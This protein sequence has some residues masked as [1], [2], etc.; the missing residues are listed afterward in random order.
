V[1]DEPVVTEEA[2]VTEAAGEVTPARMDLTVAIEKSGPCKKH[3]RVTVPREAIDEVL[4]DAVQELVDSADVP[5][6]RK[7]HVPDQLIRRR[8]KKELS[9]QVKQKVLMRSLEQ[10]SEDEELEPINEPNLDLDSIDVPDE[11]DFEYEFDIEVRPEFELPNY[12]GLK[13]ERPVRE[14]TEQNID[15][16]IQELLEQY[17][18]LEPVDE[19]AAAGD[20]VTLAIEFTH[21]GEPL[22]QIDEI[23]VR[24]RPTL[25][26][27][28]GELA[29]FD[30][31]MI[32][33]GADD[34]READ[35]KVSMEADTI[36][37]RGETVHARCTV[38]DVKRLRAQELNQEFLD[39]LSIDSVE[40]LR[41]QVR[42]M[43]E[44]QVTYE[45]RQATRQQVLAKITDSADWD[46]PEDLVR[47]QVENA[48]RREI[49]EMQQAGFTPRDIRARENDLRQ[50]SISMTRQNLKQHFVLDRVAEEEK[51]EVTGADVDLEIAVMAMQSGENARRMRA[52]LQKSGVIENLEAQIRERKAVD[53]ILEHAEFKDVPM[54][55]PK[56][57]GVEAVDRSICST[58]T[59]TPVEAEEEHEHDHDGGHDHDHG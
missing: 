4:D 37:M 54:K 42:D 11:G 59:D 45:Q 41:Q 15:D 14:V 36:A 22:K 50:R 35:L 20:F 58:I 55:A 57:S 13:I 30:K 48:L 27:Q 7:G 52:R 17:G 32:G 16:Y 19:P 31:L 26:F 33:A 21:N 53:V 8:F 1:A 9:E 51:L 28:D 56:E 2:E 29:G 47:K 38:L 6:F 44:R 12:K 23:S 40:K 24:V 10:I 18:Q 25:R 34:V 46:L 3:V 39:R 43:L 49:L 5:G